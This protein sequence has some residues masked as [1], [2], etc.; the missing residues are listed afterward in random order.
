MVLTS[1]AVLLLRGVYAG[2]RSREKSSDWPQ[3]GSCVTLYVCVH[4]VQYVVPSGRTLDMLVKVNVRWD[5][6]LVCLNKTAIT[7]VCS[8][9]VD[10]L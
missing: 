9:R 10:F 4:M 6:L 5:R 8:A 3:C 2:V 7:T 1:E